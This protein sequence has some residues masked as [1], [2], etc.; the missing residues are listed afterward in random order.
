MLS[1]AE[2]GELTD[3]PWDKTNTTNGKKALVENYILPYFNVVKNCK[4]NANEG[5]FQS[6]SVQYLKTGDW[7]NVD[8]GTDYYKFTT[9]DGMSWGVWY[10]NSSSC[11]TN[12]KFCAAIVVDINGKKP[13][14]TAGMDV[15]RF[16]LYPITNEVMPNGVY[17]SSAAYDEAKKEYT[18]RTQS[19]IDSNC[20][21][22]GYGLYCA[23][24]VVAE[25]FKIN[26]L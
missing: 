23:A 9:A 20:S 14:Y 11:V 3:W 24:K 7:S 2:N 17:D 13:P 19:E 21:K 15:F 18:R 22:T 1:Q 10:Y 8:A 6:G 16:E 5:C 12:K 25:G 4:L 26:Y